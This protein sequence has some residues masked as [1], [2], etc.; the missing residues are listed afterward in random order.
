MEWCRDNPDLLA[1]RE[2][3][4][5]AV[6]HLSHASL[7][8]VV[9]RDLSPTPHVHHLLLFTCQLCGLLDLLLDLVP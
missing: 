9:C 5:P 1:L 6:V 4:S 7:P 2:L 8:S 3:G